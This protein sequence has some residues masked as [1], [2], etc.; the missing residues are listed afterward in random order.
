MA[1]RI[2]FRRDLASSWTT[3][4]PVLAQ[5]EIGLELDTTKFK[6][7]DA[8]LKWSQLPYWGAHIGAGGLLDKEIYHIHTCTASNEVSFTLPS[9]PLNSGSVR[10]VPEGGIEFFNTIDFSVAGTIVSYIATS[11]SFSIGEKILFKYTE[12]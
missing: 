10:M 9:V 12:Q 8:V 11:P 7:G 6:I 3:I 4:D 1:V 2:Q 5:G